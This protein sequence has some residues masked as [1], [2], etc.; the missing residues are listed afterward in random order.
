[1]FEQVRDELL[2][3]AVKDAVHEPADQP[4]RRLLARDAGRPQIVPLPLLARDEPL[5]E[6]HAEQR[7]DGGECDL[8]ALVERGM[9]GPQLRRSQVPENGEDVELGV[10]RP[11][12]G[13]SGHGGR[14]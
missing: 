8:A 11:V 5:S 13:R 1:M 10:G 4:L 3:R 7:G 14:S 9:D 6:H 2:G 12:G